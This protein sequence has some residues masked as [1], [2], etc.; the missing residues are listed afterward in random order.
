MTE[1]YSRRSM[2][3]QLKK[4]ILHDLKGGG[5][6]KYKKIKYGFGV[7]GCGL[8]SGVHCKA[9]KNIENANLIAVSDINENAA[10]S[11]AEEYGT[12]YYTDY[13]QL[14]GRDDIDV[15]CICTPSGLRRDIAIAAARHGKNII[16]E[17]PIEISIDRIN[18]I[19]EECELNGVSIAGIFS[20]RYNE[21]YRILKKAVSLDRF[22]KLILGD[23]FIKWYRDQKYYDSAPW[24]GTWELDGGGSLMNQSIHY[25]DLL[26]WIM[27][28]VDEVY[29]ACGMLNHERVEVEDTATAV[30]KFKNGAQGI[31]EGT[32]STYPG[33]SSRMEIH[34]QKGSVLIENNTIKLWKF[35]DKHPID[36]EAGELT[37]A[38]SQCG[39][40]DP[41]AIDW[42][43]HKRQIEDILYSLMNGEE[44][45]VDGL[46]ARK[47]VEIIQAIY[48][49]SS[50]SKPIRL[51]L[52][53]EWCRK[54]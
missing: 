27:G 21:V 35:I 25:I 8:I 13:A 11:R 10:R 28:P 1:I 53:M 45:M 5:N 31:I 34:G 33:I 44:A 47:A 42:L 23:V 30:V 4:Y 19:L 9:I 24:R 6:L 26:Q 20:L 3:L 29:G 2:P 32:T 54:Q 48:K 43:L 22:G 38:K 40:S 18:S 52:C 14:L 15:V 37:L 46:E 41:E 12:D 7:I 39:I 16:V 17:K 51:P 50:E 49:S 36:K